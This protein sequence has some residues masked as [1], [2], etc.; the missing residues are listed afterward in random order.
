[1][2]RIT[3]Q[4]GYRTE[5]S[6]VVDGHDLS[7]Q[8]VLV[9][10]ASSGLG[11]E[12]ARALASVG[13]HVVL[14]VRD[15]DRGISSAEEILRT[16]PGSRVE[17]MELDLASISSIRDFAEAFL[18]SHDNLDVLIN[19]AA[20]M[21]TPQGTT[22]DGFELQFGTNHLGHF[23]LFRELLPALR[24]NEG[25]R[26]VA[27][28]SIGHRRSN[29]IFDDP[30][31][32]NRDYEKWSAYGQS[33]TACSLFALGVTQRFASEGIYANAVHPGG[34]ITGLQ[35]SLSFDEQ[36]A[37]GW[38]DAEGNVNELFKTVSQGASTSL[39]AA[40]GPELSGVGGLYLEDCNES[41]V[42]DETNPW[43][44]YFPYAVDPD[45]ADRL[46]DISESL[47]AAI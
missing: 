17:V 26:I 30:N 19:N 10:G 32:K 7:G 43:V 12:T 34:I 42:Y 1:M 44:G 23:E 35:K 47:V 13:A 14:P 37:M 36:Q 46:W 21:A 9:T 4:F 11:V 5:A 16:T 2:A 25:A 6:E 20:V 31:F 27:L 8:T 29:V 41:V 39:W 22:H 28:T 33:K 40:V 24:A 38:F 15:V 3:S 18:A 45:G